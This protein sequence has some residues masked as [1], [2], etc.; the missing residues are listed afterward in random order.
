MRF[1]SSPP[2]FAAA[3]AAAEERRRVDDDG[4]AAGV[5]CEGILLRTF[6]QLT[7][8]ARTASENE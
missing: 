6:A 2:F 5:A 7:R 8:D 3:A 4:V 1:S